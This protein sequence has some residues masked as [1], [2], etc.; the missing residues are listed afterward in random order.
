MLAIVVDPLVDADPV[1]AA[2]PLA[3]PVAPVD[4]DIDGP[5]PDGIPPETPAAAVDPEL[6]P[7]DAPVLLDPLGPAVFPALAPATGWFGVFE[8]EH[9]AARP[10]ARR[11]ESKQ[12]SQRMSLQ[13]P[14]YCSARAA[15]PR[16]KDG[17][18]FIEN[19]VGI[20]FARGQSP[21]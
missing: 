18:W 7:A 20:D 10:S 16:S 15:Q 13:F 19:S 14:L 9:A 4:G 8:E 2:D 21:R 1:L 17:V 3:V 11:P 12:R 5:V 6:M